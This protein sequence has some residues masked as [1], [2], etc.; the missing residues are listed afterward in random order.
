MKKDGEKDVHNRNNGEQKKRMV[1]DLA[2]EENVHPIKN[3][4]M[5]FGET[6]TQLS[7]VEKSNWKWSQPYK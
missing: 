6:M 4:R 3:G 2:T 5:D 7:K 1:G